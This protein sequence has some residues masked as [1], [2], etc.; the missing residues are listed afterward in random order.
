MQKIQFNKT[1]M[2]QIE[3]QLSI[4]VRALPVLEA[5]ET[6]LRLE[7][8][9]LQSKIAVLEDTLQ[10]TLKKHQTMEPLWAEMPDLISVKKIVMTRRLVAGIQVPNVERIEYDEKEYS[11]FMQPGWIPGGMEILKG[12]IAQK[13]SIHIQKNILVQMETARRK[14][15]Q[16]VNLYKKVQIPEFEEAIRKIKRFLEDE[17]TLSKSSQKIL[18]ARFAVPYG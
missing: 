16:K 9:K 7:V 6:A 1:A 3:K 2:L 18:K 14:T 5:K 17:E 13:L 8:K 12:I 15:T 11:P 4:R 10:K